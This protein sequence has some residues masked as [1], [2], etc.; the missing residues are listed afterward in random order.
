MI[1]AAV[2]IKIA[3]TPNTG[4][5]SYLWVRVTQALYELLVP[6]NPDLN[7]RTWL[8]SEMALNL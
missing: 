8:H 3:T 5:G 2:G 4:T 6:P 1:A 7:A